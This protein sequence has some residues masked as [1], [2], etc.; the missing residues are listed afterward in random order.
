MTRTFFDRRVACKQI[1]RLA[2]VFLHIAAHILPLL[3]SKERATHFT[4][5]HTGVKHQ[6]G[7]HPRSNFTFQTLMC[8]DSCDALQVAFLL[9]LSFS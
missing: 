6:T 4:T 2:H 1:M 7:A 8:E 5:M 3:T 9:S